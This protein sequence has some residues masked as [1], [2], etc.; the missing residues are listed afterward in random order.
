M[1][2]DTFRQI[3]MSLSQPFSYEECYETYRKLIDAVD[4]K[5]L[6]NDP[7]YLFDLHHILAQRID[8]PDIGIKFTVH[9]NLFC[10]SVNQFGTQEHRNVLLNAK[11]NSDVIGCFALTEKTAGIMSGLIIETVATYDKIDETYIINTGGEG[12]QKTWISNGMSATHAV[13]F[14]KLIIDDNYDN[15]GYSD[16][17]QPFFVKIRNND[18]K[19]IQGIEIKDMGAKTL[20]CIFR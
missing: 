11:H 4:I 12:N 8:M 3:Y 7:S 15:I 20:H 6:S 5:K 1:S 2:I 19:L 13:I 17:I 9:T 16:H 10:G 14:A 18:G